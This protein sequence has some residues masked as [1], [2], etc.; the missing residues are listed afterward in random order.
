MRLI[1]NIISARMISDDF[2]HS[3]GVQ[4][5]VREN[6]CDQSVSLRQSQRWSFFKPEAQAEKEVKREEDI[7]HMPV[8]GAVFIFA[9]A[10][11]AFS[12]FKTL[13]NPPAQ[14][15]G[16]RH[17]ANRHIFGGIGESI[18]DL[19]VGVPPEQQPDGSFLRQPC[20]CGKDPQAGD[21][22]KDRALGSFS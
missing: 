10:G 15:G 8:P 22:H 21:V 4:K 9:H 19:S 3:L 5:P 12:I 16:L 7:G 11:I 6:D 14:G 18:F 2:Y 20:V 1:G 13:L 17:F